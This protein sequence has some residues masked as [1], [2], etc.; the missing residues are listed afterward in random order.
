[1]SGASSGLLVERVQQTLRLCQLASVCRPQRG[2]CGRILEWTHPFAPSLP[3]LVL[4]LRAFS[5]VRITSL[6][7]PAVCTPAPRRQGR[8]RCAYH[9]EWR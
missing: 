6:S 9:V 8:T 4:L 1:M 3:V 7:A 5:L 2:V